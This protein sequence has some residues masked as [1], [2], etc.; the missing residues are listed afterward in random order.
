M[1]HVVAVSANQSSTQDTVVMN[2]DADMK[3]LDT[4]VDSVNGCLAKDK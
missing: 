3:Y 1:S 2:Q 4:N